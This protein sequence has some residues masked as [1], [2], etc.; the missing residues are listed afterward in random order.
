MQ[1]TA[2][3]QSRP[4]DS[5]RLN[6]SGSKQLHLHG[7]VLNSGQIGATTTGASPKPTNT[8]VVLDGRN[9]TPKS[10]IPPVQQQQQGA[11]LKTMP[12]RAVEELKEE[13]RKVEE[14]RKRRLSDTFKQPPEQNTPS[15]L[16]AVLKPLGNFGE[17]RKVEIYLS[18]TP[19]TVLVDIPSN[20]ASA[21]MEAYEK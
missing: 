8:Y 21:E 2:T 4:G 18:E 6:T 5:K 3:A 17:D 7:N 13:L 14:L 20:A 1:A 10:L 11:V 9:V 12:R 16:H 19:T 15:G